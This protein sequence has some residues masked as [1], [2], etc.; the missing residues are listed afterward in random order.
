MTAPSP[1][2][3]LSPTI[4]VFS[5]QSVASSTSPVCPGRPNKSPVWDYF[6]VKVFAKSLLMMLVKQLR[7]PVAIACVE[8]FQQI[9]NNT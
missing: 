8:N 1:A 9:L 5:V 7:R 6:M 2:T 4:S 3:P